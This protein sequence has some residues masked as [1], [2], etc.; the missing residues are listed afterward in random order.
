MLLVHWGYFVDGTG[1]IHSS[2]GTGP[3]S[4]LSRRPSRVDVVDMWAWPPLAVNWV[5]HG[6]DGEEVKVPTLPHTIL[7]NVRFGFSLWY[8]QRHVSPLTLL[9]RF[10]ASFDENCLSQP[11]ILKLTLLYCLQWPVGVT[12]VDVP[13]ARV[14]AAIIAVVVPSRKDGCHL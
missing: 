14:P 2:Q 4:L 7:L 1:V 10:L 12:R 11:S 8:K 3:P 13:T 5:S 6:S 9:L